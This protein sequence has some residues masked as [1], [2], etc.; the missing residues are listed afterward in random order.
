MI[1]IS[2]E[3]GEI[4]FSENA[5][6]SVIKGAV[7]A[8]DGKAYIYRYRSRYMP[9]LPAITIEEGDEG[10]DIVVYIVVRF[11]TSI[12]KVSNKIL[13]NIYKNLESA[14]NIVP[15]SVKVIVTGVQSKDIARRNIEFIR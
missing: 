12:S 6:K 14:F 11:G 15:D 8:S 13:D 1:E 10:Y 2:T 9:M 5:V 7:D 4:V 3:T